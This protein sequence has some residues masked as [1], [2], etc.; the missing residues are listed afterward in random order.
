MNLTKYLPFQKFVITTKL[1]TLEVLK[2]ISD[3]IEQRQ[4]FTIS[5]FN[6][7]YT[8][9]YT[10]HINGLTFTMSRNIKYRNS[11][12]PVIT[13]QIETFLGETQI[14]VKM[15][16]VN[17]V[18]IFISFWLSVV[19]SVCIGI[20]IAG[21]SQFKQIL[22]NGFSLAVLIPFGMFAFGCV[23]TILPFK[24]ES[25]TSIDFLSKLLDSIEKY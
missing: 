15:R 6:R 17:F 25:K 5:S 18:L 21:L 10:G 9:P 20:I 19:G 14:K 2:R 8:K 7:K 4:G 3:N 12:A 24:Y 13:G 1:P 22:Q 16:L 23:L 11:F